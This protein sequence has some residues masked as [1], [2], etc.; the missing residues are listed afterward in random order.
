MLLPLE[1][2]QVIVGGGDGFEVAGMNLAKRYP[3]TCILSIHAL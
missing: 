1:G 2:F 3:K